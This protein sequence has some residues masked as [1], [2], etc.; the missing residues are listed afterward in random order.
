MKRFV[1]LLAVASIGSSFGCGDDEGDDDDTV[2]V[3]GGSE[4]SVPAPS[5]GSIMSVADAMS[6]ANSAPPM[7][8]IINPGAA[9]T[10]DRDCMGTAGSCQQSL[11]T[12]MQSIPLPGGYCTAACTADAECGPGGGC[13]IAET[14]SKLSIPGLDLKS[15]QALF[16]I[17]SSC[18]DRCD[19]RAAN[20]CRDG[21]TCLSVR[22]VIPQEF[23]PFAALAG[24]PLSVLAAS[25]CV[26]PLTPP[27]PGPGPTQDAGASDAGTMTV[28]GLD[29][30]LDAGQ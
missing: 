22:E 11:G 15:I 2:P 10:A 7:M 4:A 30:G 13:P 16:P 9:C 28:V 26:P 5:D 17:P 27:D 12:G 14:T 20:D 25:Y 29:G 6:D 21:Y 1:M 8:K 18:L 19:P 3:D 24:V 23:R